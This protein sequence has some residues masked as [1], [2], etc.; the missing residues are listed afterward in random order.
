MG[1]MGE[2]YIQIMDANNGVYP[3]EIGL[4]EAA[5]MHRLRLYNKEEYEK[6]KQKNSKIGKAS[7]K[8]NK[9]SKKS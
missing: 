3:E 7:V 9:I 2:L 6:W 8:S 5:E 4:K 1:K